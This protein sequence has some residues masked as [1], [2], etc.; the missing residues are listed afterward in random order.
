M[1]VS[2]ESMIPLLK[3]SLMFNDYEYSLFHLYDIKEYRDFYKNTTRTHYLDNSAYEAQFTDWEFDLEEFYSLIEEIHPTHIIVPDV[4]GDGKNTIK[5]FKEFDFSRISED[6]KIIGVV[7]GSTWKEMIECFEFLNPRV[8]VIAI[9]FHS[10]AYSI[11]FNKNSVDEACAIGRVKFI[12]DIIKTYN[13][14]PIHLIGMKLPIELELYSEEEKNH[15]VSIDTANPIQ[16][17]ML[18][19]KYPNDI[20][21]IEE[22]PRFIMDEVNIR[23]APNDIH[24]EIIDYNIKKFKEFI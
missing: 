23:K 15:I 5:K 14:K 10:E 20:A 24:K 18:E 2:H 9:P 6:I 1:K 11:K 21:D 17:G 4:I 12:R 7:Q 13:T 19:T 3:E 22:K 8:D 16:F